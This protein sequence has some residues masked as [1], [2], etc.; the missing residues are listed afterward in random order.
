MKAPNEIEAIL[1]AFAD[2]IKYNLNSDT[3][4]CLIIFDSSEVISVSDSWRKPMN[5]RRLKLTYISEK[6]MLEMFSVPNIKVEDREVIL[7]QWI[8]PEL[9]KD[10]QIKSVY[11]DPRYQAFGIVIWSSEFPVAKEGDALE[12][13]ETKVKPILV[14][15]GHTN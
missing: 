4:F 6:R 15:G 7:N 13:I 2:K 12:A 10:S 8:F 9:P 1:R 14:H 5:N 3:H 11:Y